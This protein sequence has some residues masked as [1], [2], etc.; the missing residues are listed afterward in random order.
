MSNRWSLKRNKQNK[1]IYL[2]LNVTENTKEKECISADKK[3]EKKYR[4]TIEKLGN[5]TKVWENTGVMF[6]MEV[7]PP[8]VPN[9]YDKLLD[10]RKKNVLRPAIK[11]T[12]ATIYL[13]E[14][15]YVLGENYEAHQAIEIM[16]KLQAYEPETTTPK[17]KQELDI[18]DLS[19]TA[20]SSFFTN[21]RHS[22]IG[23]N[24]VRVNNPQTNSY[25]YANTNFDTLRRDNKKVAPTAPTAPIHSQPI[26]GTKHQSDSSMDSLFDAED[27]KNFEKNYHRDESKQKFQKNVSKFNYIANQKTYNGI[28]PNLDM[29]SCSV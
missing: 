11:Q 24:T 12:E 15:G 14:R 3:N 10:Y 18:I 23:K 19:P 9:N 16:N 28:Y 27:L 2:I 25:L 13:Y 17:S 21:K 6:N 29:D 5:T 22:K 8:P 7:P 26:F 20:P 4:E 1:V